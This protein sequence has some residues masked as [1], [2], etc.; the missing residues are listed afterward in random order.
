MR[1]GSGAGAGDADSDM[2]TGGSAVTY[3][4]RPASN[5][6]AQGLHARDHAG[7]GSRV[8]TAEPNPACLISMAALAAARLVLARSA[9]AGAHKPVSFAQNGH[10]TTTQLEVR[11]TNPAAATFAFL[12]DS[13]AV[14]GH[15]MTADA[16]RCDPTVP[17]AMSSD[18][19]EL[20]PNMREYHTWLLSNVG[21]PATVHDSQEAY[22]HAMRQPTVSGPDTTWL[23]ACASCGLC[24]PSLQV[25]ERTLTTRR[26]LAFSVDEAVEFAA[27]PPLRQLVALPLAVGKSRHF[28]HPELVTERLPHSAGAAD[29]GAGAPPNTASAGLAP[30][31]ARR[32]RIDGALGVTAASAPAAA[33]T[34]DLASAG[35]QNAAT[36]GRAGGGG[37]G[38]KKMATPWALRPLGTLAGAGTQFRATPPPPRLLWQS[39]PRRR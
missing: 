13:G 28:L 29:A 37:T 30:P 11:R 24:T 15:L 25:A 10:V 18:P 4:V 34:P 1:R 23:P 14:V 6:A 32:A 19:A 31:P 7:G 17:A 8:G 9:E 12:L 21:D 2:A 38:G 39:R 5:Q 36:G 33:T 27:S 16:A 22:R 20:P 35:T 3:D 26:V